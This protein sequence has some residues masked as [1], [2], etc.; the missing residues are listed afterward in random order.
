MYSLPVVSLYPLIF[1]ISCSLFFMLS[2]THLYTCLCIYKHY[3]LGSAYEN[4]C[5]TWAIL[6]GGTFIQM[7]VTI[8]F[9]HSEEE[10][11]ENLNVL[12]QAHSLPLLDSLF[13]FN[14][15]SCPLY[16]STCHTLVSHLLHLIL[17]LHK[18]WKSRQFIALIWPLYTIT[19]FVNDLSLSGKWHSFLFERINK[20]YCCSPKKK[21]KSD[22]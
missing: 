7:S 21:K 6:H 20:S 3:C 5:S 9:W 13:N 18:Y 17:T 16:I 2:R 4:H 8:E 19:S 1:S 14:S 15:L 10:V 22:S 11:L 12:G